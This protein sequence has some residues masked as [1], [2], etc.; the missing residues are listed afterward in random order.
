MWYQLD[1]YGNGLHVEGNLCIGAVPPFDNNSDHVGNPTVTR[2]SITSFSRPSSGGSKEIPKG[3]V[4]V[5]TEVIGT[6]LCSVQLDNYGAPVE[7]GDA[8]HK[9]CTFYS[10]EIEILHPLQELAIEA[11]DESAD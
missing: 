8:T 7:A 1:D 10:D 2:Q 9:V 3:S 5:I 4:G 11:P 6:S